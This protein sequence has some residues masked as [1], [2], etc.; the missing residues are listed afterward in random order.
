MIGADSG[1]NGSVD[2][3]RLLAVASDLRLELVHA[4]ELALA[5]QPAPEGDAQPLTVEVAAALEKVDLEQQRAAIK[6]RS[7]AEIGDRGMPEPAAG[8]AHTGPHRVD[9][10]RRQHRARGQSVHVGGREADRAAA[11]IATADHAF[12]LILV[13]EKRVGVLDQS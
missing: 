4:G 2:C 3:A 13:A 8:V 10:D 6:S 11:T 7:A 5:A 1:R 12:E 9:A